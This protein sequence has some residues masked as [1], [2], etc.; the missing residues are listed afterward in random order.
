M[1]FN[2][3]FL[4]F[5]LLC[6]TTPAVSTPVTSAPT[7]KMPSEIT[8]KTVEEVLEFFVSLLHGNMLTESIIT[9]YP[10]GVIFALTVLLYWGS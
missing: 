7:P 3:T 2:L 9:L 8:G 6:R 1:A 10:C 4:L 5:Y